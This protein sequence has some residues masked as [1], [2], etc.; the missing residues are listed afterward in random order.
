MT[1]MLRTGLVLLLALPA[2][3]SFADS[4]PKETSVAID[5]VLAKEPV[6]NH[7][8][9]I[10]WLAAATVDIVGDASHPEFGTGLAKGNSY[11]VDVNTTLNN[12]EFR[13]TFSDTQTLTFYVFQSGVEFGT[14]N[15]IYRDSRV[16]TGTGEGW[17]STGPISIN[18]S[19]GNHYI[20]AVSWNGSMIYHWGIGDSQ[21]VSFGFHTHGYATGTDPLPV[22]IDSDANDQ[23]IYYQRLTTNEPVV[24]VVPIT[25][26]GILSL[27]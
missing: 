14:Y 19:A 17:Y 9:N 10:Q 13:L 23:A 3:V 22:T 26:S 8:S 6:E 2:S 18:M 7:A 16:V 11:Q 12:A 4:Q 1:P 15:E 20:I 5:G 21:P 25:W 27:Y 24:P